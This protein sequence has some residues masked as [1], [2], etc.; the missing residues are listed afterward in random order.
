MTMPHEALNM[1]TDLGDH[2]VHGFEVKGDD[3]TRTQRYRIENIGM[4]GMNGK[5][6]ERGGKKGKGAAF[7]I[8]M[9]EDHQYP[10]SRNSKMLNSDN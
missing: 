3:K 5:E 10:F 7:D 6:C 4:C 8:F 9:D 2:F 1:K